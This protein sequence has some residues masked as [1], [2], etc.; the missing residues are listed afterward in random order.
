MKLVLNRDGVFELVQSVPTPEQRA[1]GNNVLR[2]KLKPGSKAALL[3]KVNTL[4]T[5]KSAL[6]G[7][8]IKHR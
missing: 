8:A 6:E 3:L 4:P 2:S 5:D 1:V 7:A